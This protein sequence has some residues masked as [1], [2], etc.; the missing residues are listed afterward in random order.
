MQIAVVIDS[1]MLRTR[2]ESIQVETTKEKTCFT[3]PYSGNVD[4]GATL[5]FPAPKEGA[6]A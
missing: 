5:K 1:K 4:G 6:Y 2:A 3:F